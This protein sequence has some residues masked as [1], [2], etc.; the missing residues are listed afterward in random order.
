MVVV[1]SVAPLSDEDPAEETTPI[2]TTTDKIAPAATAGVHCCNA[3][4]RIRLDFIR[5]GRWGLDTGMKDISHGRKV[6]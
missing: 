4:E 5:R 2:K 1:D 3:E 6:G